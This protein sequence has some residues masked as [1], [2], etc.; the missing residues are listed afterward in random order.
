MIFRQ[1]ARGLDFLQLS[2]SGSRFSLVDLQFDCIDCWRLSVSEVATHPS[3][4]DQ[5]AV[6]WDGEKWG[7]RGRRWGGAI[8][9][10]Y[11]SLKRVFTCSIYL[12]QWRSG[13]RKGL[14]VLVQAH[15]SQPWCISKLCLE[16]DYLPTESS[17]KVTVWYTVCDLET[18]FPSHDL[19]VHGH[20]PQNP[21]IILWGGRFYRAYPKADLQPA[22]Q[23]Q[24]STGMDHG[25]ATIKL[26]DLRSINFRIVTDRLNVPNF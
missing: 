24:K 21:F 1:H 22:T 4:E 26:Y 20:S 18:F 11:V 16:N 17:W 5:R 14:W 9:Q 12:D 8:V 3:G 13:S 2:F 15:L 10:I 23:V 6:A 25:M 7:G 19:L